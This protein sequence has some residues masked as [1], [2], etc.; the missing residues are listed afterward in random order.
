MCAASSSGCRKTKTKTCSRYCHPEFLVSELLFEFV[1]QL[2]GLF[3]NLLARAASHVAV[4]TGP[5]LVAAQ[6]VSFVVRDI[7]N[8]VVGQLGDNRVGEWALPFDVH[9]QC[10]EVLARH[11]DDGDV[12]D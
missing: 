7:A 4:Q 2:N 1:Q 9:A 12:A 6:V 5:N 11:S 3:D 10:G 8:P